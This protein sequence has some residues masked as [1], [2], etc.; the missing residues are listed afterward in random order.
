M[1]LRF[2]ARESFPLS[3][4]STLIFSL[5]ALLPPCLLSSLIFLSSPLSLPSL[6][7][8]FAYSPFFFFPQFP[9]L[10]FRSSYSLF[11]LLSSPF[12]LP[13]IPPFLLSY[14]IL[15]FSMHLAVF[16]CSHSHFLMIKG[17]NF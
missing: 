17:S 10:S 6:F 1:I 2:R 13:L 16:L 7:S 15:C 5:Y 9:L 8:L 11:S 3:F 12:S 14:D 4:F